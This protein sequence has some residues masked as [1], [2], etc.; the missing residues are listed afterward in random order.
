MIGE[1]KPYAT[2]QDSGVDW[3]GR[4][5]QGWG[6]LRAKHVFREPSNWAL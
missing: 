4:L 1:L 5:H 6:L 3:L 2:Y